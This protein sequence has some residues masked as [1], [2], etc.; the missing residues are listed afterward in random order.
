MAVRL[1]NA[2]SSFG[3]ALSTF[4][5]ASASFKVGITTAMRGLELLSITFHSHSMPNH[6]EDS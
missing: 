4:G 2:W 3:I 1:T 6:R 5:K